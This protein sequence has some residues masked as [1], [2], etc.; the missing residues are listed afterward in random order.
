[1]K[2]SIKKFQNLNNSKLTPRIL[3]CFQNQIKYHLRETIDHFNL[4]N[5]LFMIMNLTL[6]MKLA[7]LRFI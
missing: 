3:V 5:N 2:N 1:M 7:S 4:L 6:K